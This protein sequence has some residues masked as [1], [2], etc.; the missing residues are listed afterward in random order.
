MFGEVLEHGKTVAPEIIDGEKF[1]KLDWVFGLRL[2]KLGIIISLIVYKIDLPVEH[3]EK[4]IPLFE[5][6]EHLSTFPSNVSYRFSE[7]NLVK[8]Y[9]GF[10]YIPYYGRYGISRDGQMVVLATGKIKSWCITKGVEK[11]NIKGGYFVGRGIH[12]D[13]GNTGG[14][15]R[16]RVLAL[17][18]CKYEINPWKLV[19]NH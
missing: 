14:C 12:R 13:V 16:H 9:P 19:T 7:P 4:I 2:Y 1:V 17:T 6:G 15:T 10:F 3:W 11:K 18:F 8:F 5:D